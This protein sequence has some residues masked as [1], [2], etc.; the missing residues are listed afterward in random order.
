M[1]GQTSALRSPATT[2]AVRRALIGRRLDIGQV[3]FQALLL[4]SMIVAV[5]I[6]VSLLA[7]VVQLGSPVLIERGADFLS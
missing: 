7:D 1:T 6:L 2:E 3:C 5:G 4:G